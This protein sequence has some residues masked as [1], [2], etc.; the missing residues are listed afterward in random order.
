[1]LRTERLERELEIKGLKVCVVEDAPPS[2]GEAELPK[3]VIV[4]EDGTLNIGRAEGNGLRVNC[5]KASN[6]HCR[7]AHRDKQWTIVDTSSSNGTRLDG[8]LVKEA[9]IDKPLSRLQVGTAVLEIRTFSNKFDEQQIP[10]PPEIDGNSPAMSQLFAEM[11]AVGRAKLQTLILGE[12]GT[13]KSK[14]ARELHRRFELAGRKGKFVTV[15]CG[16]LSRELAD[17]R[18]FG[19]VKG[20]FTG[21]IGDR[22][23]PFEEARG[24]TVFI[25]EIGELPLDLQPKLLRVLQDRV[26]SRV[27]SNHE[28]KVDVLVIAATN[29]PLEG[30]VARGE[31]REDLWHRLRGAT[32]RVPPLRDRG[33][34]V[35][36]LAER[37][38][39]RQPRTQTLG[40][41]AK[42]ALLSR[43]HQWPG[44]VRELEKMIEVASGFHMDEKTL[45][46]EHLCSAALAKTSVIVA[47]VNDLYDMPWPEAEREFAKRYWAPRWRE[48]EDELGLNWNYAKLAEQ[49]GLTSARAVRDRYKK[50]HNESE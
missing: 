19:H 12:T 25:D 39:A 6:G 45:E 40:D 15:D 27:G 9:V 50:D 7:I 20:G 38:L 4:A 5:T 8:V 1:M 11:D 30:M 2:A 22:Q 49:V 35:V 17:S 43:Q 13:G 24:G 28:I 32:L 18:L 41:S 21:A 29:R 10:R 36:L 47:T 48:L 44:N 34:D 3:C 46:A 33:D 37:F 16:G 26:V 31:F 42:K 14:I 23:S